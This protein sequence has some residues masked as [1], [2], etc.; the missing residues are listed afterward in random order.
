MVKYLGVLC[1]PRYFCVTKGKEMAIE[2]FIDKRGDRVEIGDVL[3]VGF[4]SGSSAD[5]RVG[6]VV[7]FSDQANSYS[8]TER[9]PL[10]ELEW[11]IA[12]SGRRSY[13]PKTSKIFADNGR[14]VILQKAK[15]DDD[16]DN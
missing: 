1:I 11:E 12:K 2:A 9:Q 10:I 13:A 5:V 6:R 3:V 8:L 14:F 16:Q 15:V 4:R 7:A